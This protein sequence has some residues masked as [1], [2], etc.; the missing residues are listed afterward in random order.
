MNNVVEIKYG[1][2]EI[3]PKIF[4]NDEPI[5]RYMSLSE[6]IYEDIFCWADNFFDIMDLELKENYSVSLVGHKFHEIILREA[7][8]RSQYCKELIFEENQYRI[9]LKEKYRYAL[10]LND[11]YAL[12]PEYV[13]QDIK[14]ICMDLE[15]IEAL[16]IMGLKIAKFHSDYSIGFDDDEIIDPTVKYVVL[17]SDKV[18]MIRGREQIKL[19]VTTDVLPYLIDYFN[20]YHVYIAA[21]ENIFSKMVLRSFDNDATMIEFDAYSKDRYR[22]LLNDIPRR[23]ESGFVFEIKYDYFPKCFEKPQIKISTNNPS[24]LAWEN[25]L[26]IAKDIGTCTLSITDESGDIYEMQQIDVFRHNYITD[27]S[28]ELPV[29]FIK[30][31]DKVSFKAIITPS[32]AEDIKEIVYSVSDE[33][34]ASVNDAGQISALAAGSVCI[35]A[36]TPRL[37][38]RF[39]VDIFNAPTGIIV[40]NEEIT[41]SHPSEFTVSYS[42][43]PKNVPNDTVVSWIVSNESVIRIKEND[44]SKCVIE[45]VGAGTVTLMCRI[46]GTDISKRIK[47]TVSDSKSKAKA[48]SKGCYVATAVYGSYDCP[49][50]W[51]LRRFRDNFL[52]KHWMG[53]RFIDAYYAISPK[54][55][56]LFGKHKWFNNFFKKRLDKLVACLQSRGYE[57]TPYDD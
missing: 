45:S 40:S 52:D 4:I 3:Y 42:I 39:Y 47:V 6:Y 13:S 34:V 23:I 21:I 50:V 33:S 55:V 57:E 11:R 20:T 37:E 56:A 24:V 44:S 18:R 2:C 15:K 29:E 27:I 12:I 49:Q 53:R 1:K 28:F 14:F 7:M 54:A 46:E 17:L 43:I 19:Y 9:P 41:L 8:S 36:S 35:T 26:L 16:N 51:V 48:K 30:V 5:S 10:T 25:N 31:G 38:R 32:D 22:L